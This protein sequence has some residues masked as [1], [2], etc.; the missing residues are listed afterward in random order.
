VPREGLTVTI[1][2]WV[3][4]A[5]AVLGVFL[6]FCKNEIRWSGQVLRGGA[7]A[8]VGLLLFTPVP[9]AVA[10]AYYSGAAGDL[11]RKAQA[12]MTFD[13]L[14][15]ESVARLWWVDPAGIAVSALL[16]AAVFLVFGR[17]DDQPE[18]DDRLARDGWRDPA[19]PERLAAE[20]AA[21]GDADHPPAG[22]QT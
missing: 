4:I 21:G 7:V 5:L 9:I 16:I 18:W 2:S 15:K 8:L 22:S 12:G 11:A 3:E 14:Y 1:F 6:I 20:L 19:D 17:A 10:I 13:A